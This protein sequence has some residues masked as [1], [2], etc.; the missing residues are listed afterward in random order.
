MVALMYQI[1]SLE[2]NVPPVTQLHPSVTLR[3]MS[4]DFVHELKTILRVPFLTGFL[5]SNTWEYGHGYFSARK[6]SKF[7]SYY[8]IIQNTLV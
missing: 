4:H 1:M 8:C 5:Q 6:L 2:A 7:N 3:E